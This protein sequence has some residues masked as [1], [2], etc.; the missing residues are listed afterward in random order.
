MDSH[1]TVEKLK[2]QFPEVN[3]IAVNVNNQKVSGWQRYIR[4]NKF[5]S[6]HEYIFRNPEI[7][8]KI[9]A[10]N[11]VYKVIVIDENSEILVAN[12]NMFSTE[13]KKTLAALTGV[14]YQ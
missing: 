14:E 9:L 5:K 2:E 11:N 13:F 3:F 7:A 4:Q 8:K 6:E 10:L 1:E 12:A